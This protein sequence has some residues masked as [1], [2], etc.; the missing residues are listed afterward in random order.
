M[1]NQATAVSRL[2]TWTTVRPHISAAA[3]HICAA[4]PHPQRPSL[5]I[6][7]DRTLALLG[8]YC[9]PHLSWHI[10]M[11]GADPAGW[12]I[13]E[14]L[15]FPTQLVHWARRCKKSHARTPGA[16][17]RGT[18]TAACGPRPAFRD[19]ARRKFKMWLL[20]CHAG[21]DACV[22]SRLFSGLMRDLLAFWRGSIVQASWLGVQ[23]SSVH[24]LHASNTVE[25]SGCVCP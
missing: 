18:A 12:D 1:I 6:A 16:R 2:F 19:R 25:K 22:G 17:N 5:R 9:G 23:L 14:S 11:P 13:A 8:G 24:G 10:A 4:S 21:H 15:G 20:S 3:F 7:F